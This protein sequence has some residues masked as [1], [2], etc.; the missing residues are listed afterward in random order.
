M[1][2]LTTKS[3]TRIL[4]ETSKDTLVNMYL[5][6]QHGRQHGMELF[7]SERIPSIFF[8][9]NLAPGEYYRITC[10]IPIPGVIRA[11][12]T[13]SQTDT[14]NS[15]RI[16][17][18]GTNRYSFIRSGLVDD[19]SDL[20]KSVLRR[21]FETHEPVINIHCGAFVT[22]DDPNGSNCVTEC[23]KLIPKNVNKLEDITQFNRDQILNK[24]RAEYRKVMNCPGLRHVL[25]N[26]SN[27]ISLGRE[28]LGL[29]A[30]EMRVKKKDFSK[31]YL[32]SKMA[33]QVYGEYCRSLYE[34]IEGDRSKF[35]QDPALIDVTHHMHIIGHL[36]IIMLDTLAAQLFHIGDTKSSTLLGVKQ[37]GD[38]TFALSRSGYF[39]HVKN[40]LVVSEYP[41]A[42]FAKMLTDYVKQDPK[43]SI[44]NPW[45][46]N[47][48]EVDSLLRKLY[49]WKEDGRSR[50]FAIVTSST[51][52]SA[53]THISHQDFLHKVPQISVAN[54]N[55]NPLKALLRIDGQLAAARSSNYIDKAIEY[56]HRKVSEH[57]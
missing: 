56:K 28:A 44:K 23:L 55:S 29:Q 57:E 15:P 21:A 10:D 50:S 31:R 3:T 41:I 20:T 1:V 48:H 26:G 32:L 25:A 22:L 30:H 53:V 9:E 33:Y 11:G 42:N 38:I 49:G 43:T 39:S 13:T 27:I 17:V 35:Y 46:D 19:H 2:G 7:C 45:Y 40:L 54:T 18:L 52:L 37:M 8:F 51:T 16:N 5:T 34:D 36:G 14:H 47:P 4:I 12:F 24:I 6:D